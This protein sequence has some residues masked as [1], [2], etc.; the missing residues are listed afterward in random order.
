MNLKPMNLKPCPACG[1]EAGLDEF[2]YSTSIRCLSN[3]CGLCGPRYDHDGTKWNAMLQIVPQRMSDGEMLTRVAFALFS[4]DVC[5][6]SRS[7]AI[8][9][10]ELDRRAKEREGGAT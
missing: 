7:A 3:E 4:K 8:V 1:G 10:C 6:A 5:A 9:L 2:T